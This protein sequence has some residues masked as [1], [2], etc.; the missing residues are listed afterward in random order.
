M[1]LEKTAEFLENFDY[2]YTR[3]GNTLTIILAYNHRIFMDFKNPNKITIKDQLVTWNFIT[4]VLKMSIRKAIILNL[5][6]S[7]ILSIII[8]FFNFKIGAIVF[9]CLV[10]WTTYWSVTHITRYENLKHILTHG[11][12]SAL[13]S[14]ES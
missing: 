11:N 13:Y 7:M 5:V 6:C 1:N 12:N 8:A 10:L 2:K 4:G 3:Q 9:F 14:I